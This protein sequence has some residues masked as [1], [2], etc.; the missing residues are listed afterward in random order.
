[1]IP[2]EAVIDENADTPS[3]WDP[4][5]YKDVSVG[6]FEGEQPEVEEINDDPEEQ[7]EQEPEAP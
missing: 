4:E 6:D 1:M 2:E 3:D 7:V 5:K